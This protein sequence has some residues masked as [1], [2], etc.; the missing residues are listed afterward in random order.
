MTYRNPARRRASDVALQRIQTGRSGLQHSC[1]NRCP[2]GSGK[3]EAGNPSPGSWESGCGGIAGAS[4]LQSPP[5]GFVGNTLPLQ[6]EELIQHP[7]PLIFQQSSQIHP[8]R[9]GTPPCRGEND[10]IGNEAILRSLGV[11]SAVGRK[12]AA[13]FLAGDHRPEPLRQ[14]APLFE[15]NT[16]PAATTDLAVRLVG[17]EG[18]LPEWH[19]F[20]GWNERF[21]VRR[22]TPNAQN[23]ASATSFRAT[24]RGANPRKDQLTKA[25]SATIEELPVKR[26]TQFSQQP[27]P[28]PHGRSRHNPLSD[29]LLQLFEK[30]TYFAN[31]SLIYYLRVNVLHDDELETTPANERETNLTWA[32][33]WEF[34]KR[35]PKHGWRRSKAFLSRPHKAPIL[36]S[37]RELRFP[38]CSARKLPSGS[39]QA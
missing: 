2:A 38:V 25:L 20:L 28:T 16:A 14:I 32:R 12:R 9:G 24:G 33:H 36:S 23:L 11:T 5:L 4:V 39:P 22:E 18:S 1:G 19:R 13:E 31:I 29:R 17:P 10:A 30:F 3:Y 7:M 34:R 8:I 21:A 6:R 37:C 15:L 35:D 27:V 26:S